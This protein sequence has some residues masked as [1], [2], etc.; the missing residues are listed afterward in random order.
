MFGLL[1]VALMVATAATASELP[2]GPDLLKKTLAY[3]DPEG[4]WMRQSVELRIET[5]YADG[6]SR[7]RLSTVDYVTAAYRERTEEDGR[8]LEQELRD[9][10]CRFW[11][12]GTATADSTV[13]QELGL[14]CERTRQLRDYVSYL[15]GLPMKLQDLGTHVA[16]TVGRA[17]FQEQDVLDLKIT[18]D[19]SVG[20]DVWHMYV[21]PDSGR[22][23]GYG[24]YKTAAEEHG[25]YIVLEGEVEVG[26]ARIP[27]ARHWYKVP[28]DGFLGT[29][30]LLSGKVVE[31]R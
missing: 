8:V 22:L 18:Y 2:S 15:W 16:E 6:R 24:F 25:E 11:V 30:T 23:V 27:A 10:V 29:D 1:V 9:G 3:H 17:V 31:T 7:V 12:D 13:L 5:G 14:R 20:T 21:D 26:A 28:G 19:P 4:T